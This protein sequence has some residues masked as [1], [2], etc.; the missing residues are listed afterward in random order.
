MLDNYFREYGLIAIFTAVAIGVPI[1]ILMMSSMA[2]RIGL[3]PNKPTEVKSDTYECGVEPIG[4]RWELFNFRY[5]M[6]AIL[7]V[8]FD[9]EVVFLYPWA[10]K[11]NQLELFAL[12]E[13]AV[14]VGILVVALPDPMRR[15][16]LG[17]HVERRVDEVL[18]IGKE[19]LH[20][21]SRPI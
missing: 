11:F 12:I 3:R 20:A 6:F 8:I 4:G 7:F 2:G 10:A 5:Y 9:V 1:S 18:A 15:S 16:L 19:E 17:D 13:M 21:S 14:F